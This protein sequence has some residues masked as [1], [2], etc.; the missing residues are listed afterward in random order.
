MRESLEKR[1]ASSDSDA[2]RCEFTAYGSTSITAPSAA[3][4]PTAHNPPH[5]PWRVL[6]RMATIGTEHVFV[7]NKKKIA[8]K[9]IR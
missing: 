4:T 1:E 5:M 9:I 7:K 2:A 6:S 3:Q 8:S